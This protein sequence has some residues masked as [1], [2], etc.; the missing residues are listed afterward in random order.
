MK[1]KPLFH[2]P[3]IKDKLFRFDKTCDIRHNLFN[4]RIGERWIKWNG[5]SPVIEVF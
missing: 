2:G 5:Y 1:L 3:P 4:F